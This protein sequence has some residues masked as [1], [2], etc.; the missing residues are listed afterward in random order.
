MQSVVTVRVQLYKEEALV[1]S[2]EILMIESPLPS[3]NMASPRTPVAVWIVVHEQKCVYRSSLHQ[4]M[5]LYELIS[6]F[7]IIEWVPCI[8]FH[9]ILVHKLLHVHSLH[10]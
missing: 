9:A 8:K 10:N 5:L 6:L 3:P 4:Y 1:E 2:Q 7:H